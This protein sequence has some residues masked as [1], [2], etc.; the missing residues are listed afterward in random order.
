MHGSILRH[1]IP[2]LAVSA[3][4]SFTPDDGQVLSP[5]PRKD[6]FLE[7]ADAFIA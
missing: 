4:L 1:A 2:K 3:L 7:S 5:L 6:N